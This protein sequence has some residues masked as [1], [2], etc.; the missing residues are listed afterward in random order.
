MVMK[1]IHCLTLA[2]AL[3]AT[4]DGFAQAILQF[5]APNYG[6][7]ENAGEVLLTVQ[8]TGDTSM[9]AGIDYATIDG[10]ATNGLKYAAVSGTLSFKANETN[11]IIAVTILNNGVTEGAKSF[12]VIL[13]NPTG[14]GV[15]GTRTN[16]TVSIADNDR[17]LAFLFSPFSVSEDAGS[18]QIQVDRQDDAINAVSVVFFTSD[19][20][21]KNGIDYTGITNTVTFAPLEPFKFLYVPILNNTIKQGNRTF[22]VNLANPVNASAGDP[23]MATV[24]ILDNDQGFAFENAAYSVGEDAGVVAITLLR[25]TDDTNS[26]ATV[27]FATSDL[28][29]RNGVDYI[30]VTNTLTFVPGESFKQIEIPILNDRMKEINRNFQMILSNPG[31]GALLSSRAI[32]KVMIVDNDSGV[33][34][35]FGNYSIAESVGTFSLNVLRGNDVDLGSFTVDY[36][37]SNLTALA[38]RDYQAISGTLVFEQ[39]ETIKA[40]SVPILRDAI[41]TNNINFRLTLTKPTGNAVIGRA[42]VM[43]AIVSPS[44]PGRVRTVAPPYNTALEI[45]RKAGL[46]VLSWAGGGPLERSD[47]PAGPWQLLP[48]AT[49]SFAVQSGIPRTFYRVT[50][51]RPANVFV[52]STSNGKTALP[53]VLL[54]HGSGGT[55]AG[56]E[57]YMRL[58]PLAEARGFLYCYPDGTLG[59]DGVS[60][61]N[62][63]DACCDIYHTGI[64]DAGYLRALIEE[65]ARQFSVDRKRIYLV[66][67]SNGGE[68][69]YRMA[70][71]AADLLAG[72]ASLAGPTYLDPSHCQPSQ[73][74]N[75]LHIHGTADDTVPYFGGT[76][77]IDPGSRSAQIWASYNGASGPVIDAAPSINLDLAVAGLD[78]VVTRYADAPA[79]GAIE[80][81]TINGG[82]HVPTLYSG[83][84]ASEFAPRVI[85]WLLAHPK[86]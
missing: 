38:G 14:G 60:F 3:L 70:C 53:L 49:N 74:V 84:A 35:E 5:S 72:I 48:A 81:W 7:P 34:V 83:T 69:A 62:A 21:G 8:R 58:Q 39:N 55:G 42:S 79:G 67:H 25:G 45:H 41:V 66:G 80:L 12:R 32:A 57:D 24:T 30:G 75:I 64:D 51:P 2:M 37:T 1:S 22:R 44:D 73:P 54:L 68:M 9:E 56:Q 82:N 27:D 13:S 78:T 43:V 52:P 6:V 23:H 16:A 71:D 31:A 76:W 17:G 61:W 29:A 86:P 65:I 46:I 15:L 47:S 28:L 36:A 11:K 85:D 19:L 33:G 4:T 10:T 26:T 59:P 77:P 18:V 63:T 50:R 20:T 40:I